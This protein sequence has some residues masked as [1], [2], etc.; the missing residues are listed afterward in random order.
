M[1]RAAELWVEFDARERRRGQEKAKKFA[2]AIQRR[3]DKLRRVIGAEHFFALQQFERALRLEALQKPHAVKVR[4]DA[5]AELV[6]NQKRR[7]KKFLLDRGVATDKVAAAAAQVFEGISFPFDTTVAGTLDEGVLDPRLSPTEPNAIQLVEPPFTGGGGAGGQ[8]EGSSSFRMQF[9]DRTDLTAGQVGMSIKFDDRNER[10]TGYAFMN[11]SSGV[12]FWFRA[13]L[14]GPVEVITEYMCVN[15]LHKLTVEDQCG[16]SSAKA[17]QRHLFFMQVIHDNTFD[18]T[19]TLA[20]EMRYD[21][22]DDVFLNHR[23]FRSGRRL[24]TTMISSGVINAGDVVQ[25]VVG[26]RSEDEAHSNDMD[27]HSE[28]TFTW[29]IPRVFAR[30]LK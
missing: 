12:A 26:C 3:A 5:R 8:S 13:P 29:F 9:V 4:A 15:A 17:I 18:P 11:Q 21:G 1:S 28:S 25:I 22:D 6:R 7:V 30:M 2:A 20:S 10:E 14:T 23:V 27:V 16:F 24:R 19:Y